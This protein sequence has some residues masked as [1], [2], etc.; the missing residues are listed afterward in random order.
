MRTAI[1]VISISV[2]WLV[3]L[4]VKAGDWVLIDDFEASEKFANWSLADPDNQTRP[5]VERP[6]VTE[7]RVEHSSENHYLI[8]KPAAEGVVGNRKALSSLALPL[9]VKVGETYTF[10]TRIN[11]EYF[12]NNHSF[13]LSNKTTAEI[14]ELN[15]N[16]FEPM[17]RITDKAESDGTINSGALMV[18][19]GFKQY[20]PIVDPTADKNA[21][22][23]QTDTWYELWYVVNNAPADEG[24][25][26]FD[27]YIRGGEFAQQ[28]KV[29]SS[30]DF[31]M[32]REEPLISFMAICN[33]GPVDE[34]YGN[35]GVRYDDIYMTVGLVLH[36]PIDNAQ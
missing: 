26:R 22:R 24:G 29:F 16:A 1:K 35:G 28:Q 17:I 36:A 2:L 32:A 14:V 5:R 27:L 12:P 34:P 30:G 13:G 20:A 7:I 31:R 9:P 6:Q 18:S 23:M 3:V 25:Q 33:T 11:V 8:K 4:N 10:Y 21:D 19:K 15:Y